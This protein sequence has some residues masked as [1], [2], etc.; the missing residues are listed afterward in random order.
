MANRLIVVE[1]S[2]AFS[3]LWEKLA[4]R[5][6]AD[7]LC[8]AEPAEAAGL[9]SLA[10]LLA[11]GGVETHAIDRLHDAH[12]AGLSAPLVVGASTDHR[13]AV[14]VMQA[15]AAG[16]FALP[17]DIERL[18]AEVERRAGGIA[19]GEPP[20]PSES[21]DFSAIV[22]EHPSLRAAIDRAT[23]LIP[24]GRTTVLILGD[25]GTGKELFARA[26]HDN[27]PRAR[28]PFVAVNC[29][30]I[31]GTLLESEL[32]GHEKGSF[33]DAR[34]AKP[35]LFELADGGTI[36]LDEVSAMPHE[37][38][39]KLLRFLETR[40]IRRLGGLK[41]S[42][43]DV[44]IIAAANEDLRA[45]VRDGAFREDL[46]F[47]LAVVPIRLPPLRERGEDALLLARHFLARLA[48]TYGV[49]A[50]ELS[51]DALRTIERH[52]WPGNVRELK[53]A[54]ERGLLLAGGEPIGPEHL[55]LDEALPGPAEVEAAAGRSGGA[56][57]PFPATLEALERAAALAMVE[58]FGG[59][60]S[61]AARE[62]GI[63]RSRLYRILR[64]AEAGEAVP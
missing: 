36:F 4:A 23:R 34:T 20:P 19:E 9:G 45:L 18:E 5:V 64:R 1:C 58:R 54:I 39:A 33:T 16:Y 15:G 29:S 62:L 2:E 32:F 52:P 44:R 40:E 57:L 30:A 61:R 17:A 13:L 22:G 50:P 60:K 3:Q 25:T 35:G 11:C 56:A 38:Q 63:T 51:R 27:G 53:N 14:Q 10:T 47:R 42:T 37:L 59:N 12:R 6:D 24:G 28:Q 55:A 7:L 21:F 49:P 43:V 48:R 31:P 46:Y 8:V 41:S 26:L